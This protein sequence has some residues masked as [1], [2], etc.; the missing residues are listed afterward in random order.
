MDSPRHG[1]LGLFRA[2]FAFINGPVSFF[3]LRF[4]L[5]LAKRVS[6]PV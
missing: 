6:S 4:L 5:G 2:G 1:Q 3:I